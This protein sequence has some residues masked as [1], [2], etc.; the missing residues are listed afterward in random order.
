MTDQPV[1]TA[2]PAPPAPRNVVK[3]KAQIF[4]ST[5]DYYPAASIRLEEAGQRG[6]A[7]LRRAERQARR[8]ADASS[9]LPSSARLD[10]AAVK[11][12]KAGRFVAGIVDGAPTTDCFSTRVRFELKK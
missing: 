8:A 6:S 12:A 3:A 1:P 11:L 4:P 5:D 7:D 9:R 10:E 2:P